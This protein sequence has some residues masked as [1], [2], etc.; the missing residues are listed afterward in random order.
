VRINKKISTLTESQ[1]I[2][3]NNSS[4]S[5]QTN[6]GKIVRIGRVKVP[7]IPG[8]F[9]YEIPTLCFLVVERNYEKEWVGGRFI[10]TC[11]NLKID[12]YGKTPKDAM[13]NMAANVGSYVV[14]LFE[15]NDDLDMAWNVIS[16]LWRTNPTASKLWDSYNTAQ[17][18]LAKRGITTDNK[19]NALNKKILKLK[20][21]VAALR[22]A[23]I[24]VGDIPIKAADY[25]IVEQYNVER[26]AAA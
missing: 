11:I 26:K 2:L 14:K 25:M 1:A 3:N 19:Y 20:H 24:G 9:D 22:K 15:C 12:G 21:E 7:R 6:R 8:L 16:D 10:S 13:H 17:I 4:T 18:E 23:K 5:L